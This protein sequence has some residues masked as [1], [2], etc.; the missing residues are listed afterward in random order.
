M[1]R[2]TITD[3]NN[4]GAYLFVPDQQSF[5]PHILDNTNGQPAYGQVFL[6]ECI[7]TMFF[8][9][10]YLTGKFEV[11]RGKEPF[12]MIVCVIIGWIGLYTC[13]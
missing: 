3:D 7:G 11:S 12:A 4:P 8:V 5:Y 2:V 10:L 13:F 1:L 6:A 9:V